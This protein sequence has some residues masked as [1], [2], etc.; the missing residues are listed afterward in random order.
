[1]G[2]HAE[3][4]PLSGIL[5]GGVD[6]VT[7]GAANTAATL[8][9][10]VDGGR[11]DEADHRTVRVEVHGGTLPRPVEGVRLVLHFT[12]HVVGAAAEPEEALTLLERGLDDLGRARDGP[13]EAA[14]VLA[15][16]LGEVDALGVTLVHGEERGAP[17]ALYGEDAAQGRPWYGG[18]QRD[19]CDKN[20]VAHPILLERADPIRNGNI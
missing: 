5:R 7:G 14:L 8:A 20:G 2:G 6:A 9:P 12:R 4:M 13:E 10:T 1:M 11:H 19:N 18:E 17:A 15:G 16:D 3:R